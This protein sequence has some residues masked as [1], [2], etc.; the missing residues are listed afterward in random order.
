MRPEVLVFMIPISFILSGATIAI[1]AILSSHKRAMASRVPL[2]DNEMIAEI[3]ALRAEVADL[4]DKI[5]YMAITMDGPPEKQRII[6][7]QMTERPPLPVDAVK[8]IAGS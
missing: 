6:Q 4:R 8:S 1:V 5:N 2:P 7:A 3:R